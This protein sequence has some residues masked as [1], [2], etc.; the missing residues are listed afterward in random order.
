MIFAC[1]NPQTQIH[2]SNTSGDLSIDTMVGSTYVAPTSHCTAGFDLFYK[3]TKWN[4]VQMPISWNMQTKC[5]NPVTVFSPEYYV[6]GFCIW[7]VIGV[8]VF[9]TSVCVIVNVQITG[10]AFAVICAGWIGISTLIWAS[11]AVF[12]SNWK[13]IVR[14]FQGYNELTSVLDSI[15]PYAGKRFESNRKWT[16]IG[17]T[18]KAVMGTLLA[19]PFV[20]HPCVIFQNMDPYRFPFQ[21]IFCGDWH[22]C[23]P[24]AD[25]IVYIL[26][27]A[28]LYLALFE[29]CRFCAICF[30]TLLYLFERQIHCLYVLN[31]FPHKKDSD[32]GF[33][34]CRWYTVLR[35]ADRLCN[36]EFCSVM[37]VAM[38]SG[39]TLWV[40]VN[41]I[42]LKCYNILPL[43]VYWLMPTLS[44]V[45]FI[46]TAVGLSAVVNVRAESET[47]L[48][49]T[50]ILIANRMQVIRVVERKFNSRKLKSMRPISLKCGSLYSLTRDNQIT[51]FYDVVLRTVDGCMLPIFQ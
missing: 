39:F 32:Y 43:S 4:P 26:R 5:F 34:Y 6:W 16:L 25:W 21:R 22:Q 10:I 35:V 8:L 20:L 36:E 33:V 15:Y 17:K 9:S 46:L 3:M 44:I 41:V 42:S 7:G 23:T 29:G 31:W 14:G 37:C 27:W 1:S 48:F 45:I 2:M 11:A 19:M 49:K 12:C 38:G 28:F 51:F 30:H 40:G 13:D 47:Q 24:L 50:K 18:L